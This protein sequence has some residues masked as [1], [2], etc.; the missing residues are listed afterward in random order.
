M[1][2]RAKTIKKKF[3]WRKQKKTSFFLI[4]GVLGIREYCLLCPAP[5]PCIRV[6]TR[7][8]HGWWASKERG[9]LPTTNQHTL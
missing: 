4:V 2:L 3:G 9:L 5:F 6:F 8:I 1:R 7:I